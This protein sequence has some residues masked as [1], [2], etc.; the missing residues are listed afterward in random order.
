MYPG[1]T[2]HIFDAGRDRF[3]KIEYGDALRLNLAAKASDGTQVDFRPLY[4][5]IL[6]M[7]ANEKIVTTGTASTKITVGELKAAL[8]WESNSAT[9]VAG[10]SATLAVGTAGTG[11]TKKELL[12]CF[13]TLLLLRPFATWR[14]ASCILCRGGSEL[15]NTMVSSF[16]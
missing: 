10:R 1:D 5:K 12:E 8:Q 3:C 6:A 7:A 2:I 14:M 11:A 16:T 9:T 4:K 13:P 15:G